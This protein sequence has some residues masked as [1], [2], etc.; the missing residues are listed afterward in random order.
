MFGERGVAGGRGEGDADAH[1][2]VHGLTGWVVH[3]GV[4]DGICN[5]QNKHITCL[6]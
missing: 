5:L 6:R 3:Q 4:L 1:R 2:T